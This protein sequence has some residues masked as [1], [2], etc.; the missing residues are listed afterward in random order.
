MLRFPCMLHSCEIVAN[1]IL[2]LKFVIIKKVIVVFAVE[3]HK[4]LSTATLLLPRRKNIGYILLHRS[5]ARSNTRSITCSISR[6]TY[7]QLK[8][9][10]TVISCT[11]N[12]SQV[13]RKHESILNKFILK[14]FNVVDIAS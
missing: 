14:E 5:M 7:K 6:S 10:R 11:I 13:F 4:C 8:R 2:S 9:S 3:G 1:N 12:L